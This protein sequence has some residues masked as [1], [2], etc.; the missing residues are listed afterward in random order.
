MQSKLRKLIRRSKHTMYALIF[1]C[2]GKLLLFAEHS[3]GQSIYE[4]KISVTF[5]GVPVLK[6]LKEIENKTPF[7][8]AYDKGVKQLENRIRN[9]YNQ[10]TVAEVLRDISRETSI[11]FH[12]VNGTIVSKLK[13]P[14]TTAKPKASVQAQKSQQNR[15]VSGNVTDENGEPLAGATVQIQGTTIGSITDADGNFRFSIPE[16]MIESAQADG[17]ELFLEVSYVGFEVEVIAIGSRTTFDVSLLPSLESLPGV[18]VVSTGYYEVEQRV[19]PGNIAKVDAQTIEQQP[20]TDPLLAIQGRVAGVQIQQSSGFPGA[21]IKINIRG[22]NSLRNGQDGFPNANLPFFVIDGVPYTQTSLNSDKLSLP[23]GNPLSNLR[24]SDIESIEVLKDADATAIY[25]SRGAN[26]VVL[27]TTKKGKA[28]KTQVGVNFSTGI[29][30]VAN[31]VDLLNT[32]QYLA[33]RQEAL[34]NDGLWPVLSPADSAA[35]PDLFLWDPTRNVDWQEELLGETANQ[36][37]VSI[38]ISGGS[39]TTQFL[40]RGNF[41]RQTNVIRYDDSSF[42]GVSGHLNLNHNS[43]DNRFN[44]NISTTYNSNI[45]QQNGN[46]GFTTDVFLLPPNAPEL[47]NYSGELNFEDNFDNP[48]SYLKRAYENISKSLISNFRLSYEII[49]GLRVQSSFGYTNTKA[50]EI[51]TQPLSSLP[52]NVRDFGIATFANG[53]SDSWIVEPQIRYDYSFK[54]NH[55]MSVLAGAT[56]QE[57]VRSRTMVTGSQY[58]LDALLRDLGSAGEIVVPSNE[59][60]EYRYN[61]AYLRFGYNFKGKYVLNLTGRRDGSSRFGP[62]NQF[63]N[64]GA[65]G[66]AWIF[67]EEAFIDSVPEFLS[68]GKLRGS[69]GTTGNDLIGEYQFLDTYGTTSRPYNNQTSLISTRAPNPNFSWEI[70]KKLEFGLEFGLFKDRLFMSTSWFRNRS[71]DQ[72]VGRPLPATTGYEVQQ[73]N[74]PALIE[75]RGLEIELRSTNLVVNSFTWSTSLN[76]TSLRNELVEFPNISDFPVFDNRYA[77]GESLFGRKQFTP[78]GVNPET[79]IYEFADVNNDGSISDFDRQEF[80]ETRQDYFGGVNNSFSWKSLKLDI[81]IQFVKQKSFD[82]LLTSLP[83]TQA[84][85][86]TSVLD[87]WQAPGDISKNQ[88]FTNSNSTAR[89]AYFRYWR[90]VNSSFVRLQNVAFSWALPQKWCQCIYH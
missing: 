21:E 80:V 24:P 79:G 51:A 47:F 62:N 16:T 40:F 23:R 36:T 52:P 22:L 82:P 77:V 76:F 1:L 34:E 29:G 50:E 60:L 53:Q 75:N 69:Y 83:G 65:I 86:F 49:P 72:L 89:T 2:L 41:F 10:N 61:G 58:T 42:D 59:F 18:E 70:N 7:I 46:L 37:D 11:I 54:E 43:E 64:F 55:N 33:M 20:V 57:S 48:L 67:S 26:G 90:S 31:K 12:Q 63:G 17:E 88:R 14:I 73:F 30:Q 68:F 66:I 38:A 15:T 84:N 44:V 45:N 13:K 4:V 39:S 71:D 19:N 87:R 78:I 81:Q 56:Y 25:G 27:I 6:A 28:R 74:F 35:N 3:Y 9:E 32:Q 5:E 85:T 8:F